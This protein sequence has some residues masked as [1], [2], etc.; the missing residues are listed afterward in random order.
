MGMTIHYRG[1]LKS[2]DLIAVITEELADICRSMGWEYTCL[3]E[4]F[5]KKHT[6]RL[7]HNEKGAE[8]VGHLPLKGISISPHPKSE[9]LSFL[10]DR[11]GNLAEMVTMA[12]E[13]PIRDELPWVWIKTQSAPLEIH[14]TVVKLLK[15]LE[16]KYF[17][18]FEVSDE[19]SYWETGD[20]ALLKK[21]KDF[22]A[23][24]IDGFARVLSEA[25]IERDPND[26]PEQLAEKLE[27]LL[28]E[29]WEDM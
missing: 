1:K 14:I 18:F 24:K 23:D 2:P 17:K 28:K 22:L 16:K 29:R 4:D 26:S 5:E 21:K 6:A 15:Y 25:E 27:Q 12:I 13:G 8:I 19:G 3:D 11:N 10:F 7:V 9:S 20:A